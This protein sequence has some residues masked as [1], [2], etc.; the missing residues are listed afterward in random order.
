MSQST[1][2]LCSRCRVP[3]DERYLQSADEYEAIGIGGKTTRGEPIT[4]AF[5]GPDEWEPDIEAWELS[6]P[7]CCEVEGHVDE[8]GQLL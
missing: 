7:E 1:Q 6:C 4:A 5:S 8:E 3:L 2:H